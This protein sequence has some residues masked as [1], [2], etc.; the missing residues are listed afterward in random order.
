MGMRKAGEYE[1][2]VVE[3]P[4]SEEAKQQ[5]CTCSRVKNRLGKGNVQPAE[6]VYYPDVNCPMHGLR[7]VESLLKRT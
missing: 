1:P 5:G 3:P 4:G 6:R 2:E 7:A